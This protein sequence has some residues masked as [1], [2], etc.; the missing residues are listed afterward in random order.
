MPRPRLT[1]DY[2]GRRVGPRHLVKL[3]EEYLD[4]GRPNLEESEDIL[5]VASKLEELA[6]PR[7]GSRQLVNRIETI[8][9]SRS[10]LCW[11]ELEDKLHHKLTAVSQRY[12]H[13]HPPRR[14]P[15]AVRSKL[16]SAT[17]LP[18]HR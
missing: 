6:M 18:T 1:T 3:L 11:D 4:R 5:L 15:A 2:Q 13:T 16:F 9:R 12:R 17:S 7:T 14:L 8:D 10:A